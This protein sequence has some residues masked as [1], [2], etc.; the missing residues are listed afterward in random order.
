MNSP[1]S[2]MN[3]LKFMKEEE[4]QLFD[5]DSVEAGIR[6]LRDPLI[7]EKSEEEQEE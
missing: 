4:I 7:Y 2:S 1:D 5:L 3:H 6:R